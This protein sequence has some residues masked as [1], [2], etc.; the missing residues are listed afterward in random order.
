MTDMPDDTERPQFGRMLLSV[1]TGAGSIFMI[2][3]SAGFTMASLDNHG[4]IDAWRGLGIAALLG[5]AALCG[6]GAFALWP[7]RRSEPLSRRT[8]KAQ[9]WFNWSVALGAVLG[10]VLGLSF[11]DADDPFVLFGDDPLPFW[12]TA[13]TVAVYLLFVPIMTWRW[14]INIDEHEADAYRFGALSAA[15]L[16]LFVT[17]SWWLSWRGGFLPDPP[18]MLIFVAVTCVWLIGWAWRRYR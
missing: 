12:P 17:P 4:G 7:V 6:W 15:T 8:R 5:L 10:L 11:F 2:G 1:L 18:H 3:L 16:Y 9:R 13:I 14:W